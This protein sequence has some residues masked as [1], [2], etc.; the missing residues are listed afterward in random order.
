MEKVLVRVHAIR[1]FLLISTFLIKIGR[2]AF[3][4]NA[5]VIDHIDPVDQLQRGFYVS[6]PKAEC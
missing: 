3:I 6:V 1:Y 4:A 2:S 5:P